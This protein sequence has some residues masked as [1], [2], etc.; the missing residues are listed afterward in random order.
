MF[1][2][3][4][5]RGGRPCQAYPLIKKVQPIQPR[6]SRT[7]TTSLPAQDNSIFIFLQIFHRLGPGANRPGQW[8]QLQVRAP[9][10]QPVTR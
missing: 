10:K 6:E 4:P 9:G 2:S 3:T 8:Q 5:P 1:R 7:S